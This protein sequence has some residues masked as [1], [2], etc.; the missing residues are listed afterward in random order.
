M[1]NSTFIEKLTEFGLTRQEATVYENLLAEGKSSGYEVAKATGISRSNAYSSLA[2]LT[3]KGAAYLT[4]EGSAKKYIAV[5]IDEF[6]ENYMRGLETSRQ[7]LVTHA[8]HRKEVEE[9]Y[10]TIE[11]TQHIQNKI[12]H[13]LNGVQERVYITCQA[14][15]LPL[16]EKELKVLIEKGKK[17]VIITDAEICFQEATVYVSENRGVQIGLIVDS[18]YALTGEFGEGSMNTCLYS[19]QKNFAALYKNALANEIKLIQYRKGE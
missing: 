1:E 19:G 5:D 13:L 10:I 11:G 17:V 18:R 15:Y 2:N 14:S 12:R 7:W 9:G 8:P 6:A 16:F 4:E 3:E